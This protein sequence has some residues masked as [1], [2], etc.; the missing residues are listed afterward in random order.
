MGCTSNCRAAPQ[1][2]GDAGRLK[3]TSG[4]SRTPCRNYVPLET[5]LSHICPYQPVC[6]AYTKGRD[7]GSSMSCLSRCLAL[8]LPQFLPSFSS[9]FLSEGK[10]SPN[11]L[12]THQ[13]WSLKPKN[14]PFRLPPTRCPK[15]KPPKSAASARL[16]AWPLRS[17]TPPRALGTFPPSR[18]WLL[19]GRS[20][21][22]SVVSKGTPLFRKPSGQTDWGPGPI[23]RL[24]KRNERRMREPYFEPYA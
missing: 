23:P 24:W 22:Y 9:H 1:N 6:M 10:N 12:S 3:L 4:C 14:I 11:F 21:P 2:K 20:P 7:L 18:L 19:T 17:K 16:S 15:K 13:K 8:C 5:C